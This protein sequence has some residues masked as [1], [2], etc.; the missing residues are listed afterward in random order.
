MIGIVLQNHH[1]YRHGL[2]RGEFAGFCFTPPNLR[3]PHFYPES[4]PRLLRS[5][6]TINCRSSGSPPIA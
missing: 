5:A 1:R 6:M 2:R 3:T 4:L